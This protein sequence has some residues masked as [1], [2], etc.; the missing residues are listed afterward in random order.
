MPALARQSR[1][2]PI[3]MDQVFLVDAHAMPGT[4]D[5]FQDQRAAHSTAARARQLFVQP[6]LMTAQL[7]VGVLAMLVTQGQ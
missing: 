1:A 7:L 3:R 6:T 4:L 2:Q 5:Q